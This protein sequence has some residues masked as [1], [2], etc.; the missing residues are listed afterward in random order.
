MLDIERSIQVVEGWAE[1]YGDEGVFEFNLAGTRVVACCDY[2]RCKTLLALRPFKIA[3]T[4]LQRRMGTLDKMQGLFFVEGRRWSEQR[5][6]TAPA[7]NQQAVQSYLPNVSRVV[8][9]L[10]LQL[11]TRV[12]AGERVNVSEL[13]MAFN[14][15]VISKLAFGQDFR[16]LERHSTD[17]ADV[18]ALMEGMERRMMAPVPYGLVPGLRDLFDGATGALTRL[19]SKAADLLDSPTGCT[20]GRL[21][22]K[23]LEAEG[24]KLSREELIG[25]LVVLFIAGTDT[26]THTLS[27]AMYHLSRQPELQRAVAEEA[28]RFPPG[29][30]TAEN[31][32]ALPLARAIWSETLRLNSVVPMLEL[33][34]TEAVELG[35]RRLPAGAEIWVLTR[36]MAR[37]APQVR[38]SL[39]SDLDS[40]R[41]ARWLSPEGGLRTCAPFDSLT[42]GF[43]ARK[44]PGEK[45]ANAVGPLVLA[46]VLRRFEIAEW[47][48][49]ALREKA[50]FTACPSEDVRLSFTRRDG[51]P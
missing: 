43:G 13:L 26:S 49:P 32:S 15:D 6:L 3:R 25:N 21:L 27:W 7:F 23:L 44:C 34:T 51:V 4:G 9:S 24:G 50:K 29:L 22:S 33:E 18:T 48:G 30:A 12:D 14:A 10:L 42:F 31:V 37:R 1:E 20:S 35:G 17:L 41:P 39:G 5:R 8:E 11:Q 40:W 38:E 45:L 2:E 47:Q 28:G 46:E 16:A 36:E 19:R